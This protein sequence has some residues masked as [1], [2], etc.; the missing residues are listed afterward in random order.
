MTLDVDDAADRPAAKPTD[1][2]EITPEMIRA[3]AEVVWVAFD[4]VIAFG[5]SLGSTVALEVYRAME[6]AKKTPSDNS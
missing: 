1:T 4:E 6:Q 5:S 3:G 2:I